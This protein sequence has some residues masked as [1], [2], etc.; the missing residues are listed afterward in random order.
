MRSRKTPGQPAATGRLRRLLVILLLGVV[1]L[2]AIEGLSYAVFR[3][4]GFE[5]YHPPRV[6]NPHHPFL[7]WVHAPDIT[8]SA[9]N[10]DGTT[11]RI[12]TDADGNSITPHYRFDD[13]ELRIV[14]TGA[15]AVFG[16]G[17]S[18]NGATV[19]SMLEKLIVEELGVRA[20]VHNLAVR[21]YDSF[22]EMLALLR[23][24]TV[25]DFDLALAISGHNDTTNAALEQSRQS[26]LLPGNPHRASEF[27]RRAERDEFIL[28][29]PLSALRSCCYTFDLLARLAGIDDE[30]GRARTPGRMPSSARRPVHPDFGD[31]GERVRIT[32]TNYALMD[33]IARQR[34]ARFIMVLQPTP[35]TKTVIPADGRVFDCPGE[36]VQRDDLAGFK[37]EYLL[38]FYSAFLELD[39]PYAFIDARAAFDAGAPQAIYYRDKGH[40]N[41]RGAAFLAAWLLERIRPEIEA[42]LARK[43]GQAPRERRSAPVGTIV[44]GEDLL[45]GRRRGEPAFRMNR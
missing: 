28:R 35:E 17:T 32:Q 44:Y 27:V 2:A 19:A 9:E 10:C 15:S 33:E 11:T 23:F 42:I 25:Y 1:V 38:R 26:A 24:A 39:R 7:G 12:E 13:P 20:E 45:S 41:D 40:Y 34:D 14:I 31:I 16:I 37:R 3:L 8:V 6:V 4:A 29:S 18:G 5:R 43:A 30:S 36:D 22:Q 21:G